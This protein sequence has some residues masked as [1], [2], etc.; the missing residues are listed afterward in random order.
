MADKELFPSVRPQLADNSITGWRQLR[1]GQGQST[2]LKNM[3]LKIADI[4]LG[5]LAAAGVTGA[6]GQTSFSMQLVADN[7]F[8]V[9]GGTATGINDLLYQNNDTW[10]QQIP[11]LS[12]LNFTLSA[13]DTMF[14]VLGMGGGGQENI[15]GTVNGVDITTIDVSMSSDLS[16]YLTD[17]Q[18]QVSLSDGGS[19]AAGTY[20]A[21]LLDV[22]TAFPNLTWGSPTISYSDAVIQLASPNGAGFDFASDTAPLFSFSAADVG[23][24]PTPEPSLI[25][26]AG[27]SGLSLLFFRR[28]K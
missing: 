1:T 10:S 8:A 18:N 3:K 20:N 24:Q 4:F 27:L 13:G 22:Q 17:Y 6:Q 11:D 12:T 14:Y 2:G 15:S 28:R 25:M 5:L 16:P 7:D 26:L 9:F 23:V 19:P 21:S